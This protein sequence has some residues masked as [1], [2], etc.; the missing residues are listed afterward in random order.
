MTLV[1][2]NQD[3]VRLLPMQSAIE[4]LEPSY[5]DLSIGEAISPARRDMLTPLQEAEKC[6]YERSEE[7][8][9][10]KECRL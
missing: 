5:C 6:V 4:A 10:G 9:V 8:R 3:I 7:R 1:L 2:N